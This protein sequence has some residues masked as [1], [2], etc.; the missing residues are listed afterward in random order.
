VHVIGLIADTPYSTASVHFLE[1][2]EVNFLFNVDDITTAVPEPAS[3]ALLALGLTALAA[4][5]QRNRR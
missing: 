3:A 1:D 5:A 4:L 2:A